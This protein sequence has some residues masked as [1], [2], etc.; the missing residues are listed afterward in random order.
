MLPAARADALKRVALRLRHLARM[1]RAVRALALC[2]AVACVASPAAGAAGDPR[3]FPRTLHINS[4]CTQDLS[5]YDM[6]GAFGFCDPDKIRASNP[7]MIL[8]LEPGLNPNIPIWSGGYDPIMV[9]YGALDQWRGGVDN[10]PGGVNLGQIRPFDPA[11]DYLH[12]ADGS[13]AHLA[14]FYG[15]G[16]W[17]LAD[18]THHGTPELVAKVFAYAAK[19]DGLYAKSWDGVWSDSWIY[20]AIGSPWFY[21]SNLDTDRD[22]RPDDLTTLRRQW[23]DGL[24]R[25]GALLRQYL[26]NK[27]VGGNGNWYRPDLYA[28]SKHDGWL[29]TANCT[30]VEHLEDFSSSPDR[31]ISIAQ[32]WLNYPDPLGQ[33]RY[34]MALQMAQTASGSLLVIPP[35]ADPNVPALMLDPSTEQSMR[36]GLTLALMGGAYYEIEING[37]HR[38]SWWFDEY[39]GGINVRRSNYLGAALSAPQ[40]LANGVWRRDFANGIALNN[41]TAT[42]QIVTVGSGYRHILGSQNP[43]LNDGKPV[44]TVTIPS[45]DGV[46]LLRTGQQARRQLARQ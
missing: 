23:S 9:S 17:N 41:S 34:L 37:N 21:G 13:I 24:D 27:I 15:A 2:A 14:G 40:K 39:D 11:W 31:F 26:P 43:S 33:P 36:W 6:V 46:I 16:G 12:N 7:G 42:A 3:G 28:G 18:P 30:L 29:S 4:Y 8:L 35:G 38:T 5:R 22:G 1:H 44:S 45:H 19:L 10:I 20:G 32:Q 25:V